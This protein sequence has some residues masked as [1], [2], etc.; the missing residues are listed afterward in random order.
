M[1]VAG[2]SFGSIKNARRPAI[3]KSCLAW[4]SAG[5]D[6]S[7]ANVATRANDEEYGGTK[8]SLRERAGFVGA[9]VLSSIQGRDGNPP[10]RG[11]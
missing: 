2:A 5:S 3:S 8:S 1:V 7:A 4:A 9:A 11:L 6:A 10:A